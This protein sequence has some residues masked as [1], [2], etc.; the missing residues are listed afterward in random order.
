M[1]AQNEGIKSPEPRSE[2]VL[3]VDLDGTLMRTDMLF[4][5]FWA[6]L[7]IR[8]QNLLAALRVLPEGRAPLKRKLG[9][10]GSVDVA[11]LPINRDVL[12]YVQRWHDEGGRT[13]LV[14]AADQKLV[15]Q[16]AE[17]LGLFDEVHGSDGTLNLKGAKKA[18]FLS[19]RFPGGFSYMGDSH[20]DYA[21]WEKAT[22]AVT[23]DVPRSLRA[24]V[25]GLPVEAEHLTT[26]RPLAEAALHAMRP[27]QYLKNVLI[28]LPLIAAH[29]LDAM[30]LMQ[31]ALAFVAYSLVASSVYLLNDLLDLT[32]DRAHPRK[33]ERPLASGALPLSWGTAMA[34]MLLIAG[35]LFSLPLGPDFLAVMGIYYFVTTAY[36]FALK[37]R[38]VLDICTLASLY[39]LR[40]IA[41]GVATGI[42]LSVWL[43]AFSMFFF[44]SMAAVKRQTELVSRV[45]EG[46][47]TMQGRGY[48]SGDLPLVAN[49]AVASGYVSVLVM[50]LYLNSPAVTLLYSSTAPLWGICLIL[51]YWISRMVLLAHRGEMHDDPVVFAA[52]DRVSI[53]CAG[54]ILGLAVAGTVL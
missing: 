8:W 24:R 23:I 54:L 12:A 29:R 15:A 19:E 13:A 30:T 10:L 21:I 49:M 1:S 39:T 32:A 16:V 40:I 11:G 9:E 6:A 7:S 14:S 53:L 28:F 27:H 22:H 43:L 48:T 50:A 52:R 45:T 41:G 42:S 46:E 5:T 38:L 31:A 3:V 33:R 34:P 2:T 18:A 37:R 36:S 35:V 44:F 20:A 26:R 4:E 47:E 25:D 51:L 17:H